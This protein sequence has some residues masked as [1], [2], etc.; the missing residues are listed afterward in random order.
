MTN[1]WSGSRLYLVH[2]QAETPRAL[3]CLGPHGADTIPRICI[4][5][6]FT[7]SLANP[8]THLQHKQLL[9]GDETTF[10]RVHVNAGCDATPLRIR[11]PR[12][13]ESA[14]PI[15]V[16]KA[17]PAVCDF[18]RGDLNA[19]SLKSRVVTTLMF[20]GCRFV[21]MAVL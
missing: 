12:G 7:Q 14:S 13:P 20:I 19:I 4:F 16:L 15:Q 8:R 21:Y 9:G 18:G 5:S 17:V 10:I 6:F 3:S 1:E 11:L 2:R